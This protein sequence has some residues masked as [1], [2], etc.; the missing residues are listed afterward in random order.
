MQAPATRS[1]IMGSC[2]KSTRGCTKNASRHTTLPG[3]AVWADFLLRSNEPGN[4]TLSAQNVDRKICSH[5]LT[6]KE[7]TSRPCINNIIIINIVIKILYIP[8]SHCFML[9]YICLINLRF[10]SGLYI[11]IYPHPTFHPPYSLTCRVTWMEA[12]KWCCAWHQHK[13]PYIPS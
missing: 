6:L 7:S 10:A 9:F 12:C 11:Y 3:T 5:V 2:L 4:P 8:L 1:W 13:R